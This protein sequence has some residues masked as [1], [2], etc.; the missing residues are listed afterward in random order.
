MGIIESRRS[1]RNFQ[2]KKIP[3]EVLLRIV[4]A[5]MHAPNAYGK[6]SWEFL[7]LTEKENIIKAAKVNHNAAPALDAA[8]IIIPLYCQ[9]KEG[10]MSDWWVEDM[11]ACTQNILLKIE[12]E[13]LGGV[14][15][16]IYPREDRVQYLCEN[17][18]I[19]SGVIPF[20]MIALGYAKEKGD[21]G[22]EDRE[23]AQIH[24]E[25]YS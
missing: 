11:S 15:L 20:S 9:S 10:K 16:G 19:P 8:A 7:V 23:D 24:F 21:G 1:I 2:E 5:G 18:Y 4:K 13:G 6:R 3:K 14:W 22:F 17:F 25:R 12:E